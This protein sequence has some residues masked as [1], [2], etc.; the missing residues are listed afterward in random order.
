MKRIFTLLAISIITLG[1]LA[2]NLNF[3]M[4]EIPDSISSKELDEIVVEAS[5]QR[6]NGEVS[7]Y[8]PLA[9]QKNAA[10]NA[11]SLLS[12]MSIPQIDVDPINQAVK[13][14]HGQNVSIFIDYVPASA[15]DLQGM[16]T[17]DVKKVEYYL[18]PSDAR[19]QGA[20]YAINFVMQQ[21]EWGGYTKINADKW[22]GVNRTE[23]SLYSKLTYKRIT[24]DIFADEIYLTD[25]HK[26]Q[27]S[28]EE[29]KFIDYNGY[30]PMD[31][32]RKSETQSSLYRNNSNDFSL[33]AL[34][35]TE[36]IQISN[37]V[38]Y[39][40]T[41]VPHNDSDNTLAYSSSLFPISNSSTVASS[42]DWA[43]KYVGD[44]FFMLSKQVA[45][46]VDAIYTYGHNVSKS[47]YRIP[48]ELS[49]I[50]DAAEDV[51][52]MSTYLH[53]TWNP[54]K[55]N[56]FFSNFGVQHNWN[57][58]HYL[59]DSPSFQ[60]YDIGIYF[61]GQNYQ[62][63]FNDKWNVGAGLAWIWETNRISG[64]K[65][66]NNFP[67]TNI[68]ATWSPNDKNQLYFTANYG[69]M[70][71]STSQKSPNML[72]QDELMWYRGTPELKD[73]RYTNAMLSYTW[74]PNNRWQ[75][76][77][78]AYFGYIKNRGVTLYS[79]TAPDGAMLRQYF[80][81]GDY[82]S[83]YIGLNATGKFFGGKLVAKLRPQYWIRKTTGDYAWSSNQL[84]CTAQL[85]YYFGNFYLFGWYMTPSKYQE[86]H[87]GIISS[88]PSKYQIQL[89]W[90]KGAWNLQA[91]AYNFFHT[92]WEESKETLSSEY[93]NFDSTTF[94]TQLHTRYSVSVTYTVG[95]GKK[96]QRNSELS[97]AGTAGSAILK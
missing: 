68:N 10:Q 36:N 4:E 80:N 18:H 61:L 40:L 42:K 57:L 48:D 93:Y 12:Q 21:Y 89:G 87:S 82:F 77:A 38:S 39:S 14:A 92:S 84:T 8:I 11:I 56:Q 29:F 15:E 65:A 13:T 32:T 7:T 3:M 88:T 73:Y 91:S 64:V 34:Y 63:I 27:T 97:G 23:V 28:T 67:Q 94:G 19:F 37:R 60:K 16:K 25:R 9:L 43:L 35:N 66:D 83:D 51:H 22:F 45:M 54:N 59:G 72:R 96:V 58:I 86:T 44:S 1:C 33:R 5:N 69:S 70:F 90:G 75:L 41:N 95:Y 49:I 76:T 31:V 78:D 53:L 46:N 79:P 24:F 50:N 55:S 2:S 74:L 26:G 17:Q 81:G 62:H 85:T 47:N 6:I 52:K 71:P 20:K 30:G